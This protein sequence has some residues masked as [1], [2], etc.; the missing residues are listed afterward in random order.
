MTD[1]SR[2]T[3]RSFTKGIAAASLF[4][5][6]SLAG[7]S[8]GSD[9]GDGGSDGGDGGGSKPSFDGWLEDVSNYDGVEDRTDTDTTTV[10]VG[11]DANG[12]AYGFGPAAMTV[13]KGTTVKFEWTGKGAQ[14][15]VVD[16]D[17]A[18]ESDLYQEAGVHFEHQFTSTGTYKYYCQPHKALE[19][20]GVIVVE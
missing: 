1:D 16:Q 9:G 2:T 20:K 12:G 13:A 6:V 3:R 17:G 4:G 14:H 8:G 19:M 15:N 10:K 11:V 5:T 7:C 18:F